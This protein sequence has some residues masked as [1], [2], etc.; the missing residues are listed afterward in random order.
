MLVHPMSGRRSADGLYRKVSTTS[1]KRISILLF[2]FL[3]LVA[4]TLGPVSAEAVVEPNRTEDPQVDVV[5]T[6]VVDAARIQ[7]ARA[8]GRAHDSRVKNGVQAENPQRQAERADFIRNSKGKG[9]SYTP[10]NVD[11][12]ELDAIPGQPILLTIPK[13]VEVSKVTIQ[14]SRTRSTDKPLR[15]LRV[16]VE[17]ETNLSKNAPSQPAGSE[18]AGEVST[19]AASGE[20]SCPISST[21]GQWK[22]TVLGVGYFYASWQKCKAGTGSSYDTWV[23]KRWG[24]GK[25]VNDLENYVTPNQMYLGSYAKPGYESRF[26]T[27]GNID[28]QPRTHV[29]KCNDYF[30]MQLNIATYA[31]VVF[32][33]KGCTKY[34]VNWGSTTATYNM[35]MDQLD[36]IAYG[37]HE[38]EYAQ[39]VKVKPG[40]TPFW[41]DRQWIE[42]YQHSGWY[43]SCDSTNSN[44]VCETGWHW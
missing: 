27:N 23:Y 16:E 39:A 6:I 42:F 32:P 2:A 35:R 17:S 26:V 3:A 43:T 12:M 14:K 38:M 44:E 28:Q 19:A 33:I 7:T 11:V 25:V 18:A 10:E 34:F 24:V 29:D 5:D 8:A 13:N 31:A 41:S 20:I 21:T 36:G 30:Q 22:L 37:Q 40:Q 4:G 15:G 9:L 1:M